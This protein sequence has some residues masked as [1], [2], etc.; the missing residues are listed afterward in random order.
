MRRH[1]FPAAIFCV[2]AGFSS[3]ANASTYYYVNWTSDAL[4]STTTGSVSGNVMTPQGNLQVTYTGDVAAWTQVNFTGNDYY[5]AWPLVYR[6]STVSNLPSNVDIIT[7]SQG[8][9]FTNTLVF[10]APVVDPILDLV[11]LGAP[12]A[13]V[14]YVFSATPVI[15]SQGAASFGGCATC[16]TVNGNTVTG[17]EGNGVLK[18]AGTFTQLSWTTIGGEAWNGFTTGVL[19]I[20]EEEPA[21]PPRAAAATPEPAT[22]TGLLIGAALFAARSRHRAQR[23]RD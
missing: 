2:V 13:S 11:S 8:R 9:P 1:I 3:A 19:G 21:A 14:S 10:S 6:N 22:W 18:F 15:L 20:G 4:S 23:R 17:T 7:L 12:W 16:L 5:S